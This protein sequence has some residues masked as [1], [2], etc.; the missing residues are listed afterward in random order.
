MS[1]TGA[2][3]AIPMTTYTR[4]CVPIFQTSNQKASKPSELR[5]LNYRLKETL[6]DHPSGVDDLI[7]AKG[8]YLKAM[9]LSALIVKNKTNI[10]KSDQSTI[11]KSRAR[12]PSSRYLRGASS[13]VSYIPRRNILGR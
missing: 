11:S 5:N 10:A 8:V 6:Q 7:E 2:K 13:G 3:S 12:L 9:E 4:C 1:M